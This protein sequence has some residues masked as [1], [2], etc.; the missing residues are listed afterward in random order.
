MPD[1]SDASSAFR[2]VL[3]YIY[4]GQMQLYSDGEEE[5][6]QDEPISHLLDV[7][8]LAANL[9]LDEL[10]DSIAT[11]LASLTTLDNCVQI[12]ERAC[13]FEHA[14][15]IEHTLALID[16]HSAHFV[17]RNVTA[18]VRLPADLLAAILARDSF[19]S[20]GAAEF[21]IVALVERW[22]RHHNLSSDDGDSGLVTVERNERLLATVRLEL[23][24]ASQLRHLAKYS[25]PL[26][27]KAAIYEAIAWQND[28]SMMQVRRRAAPR[29]QPR[30]VAI[31][32]GNAIH[33]W[34]VNSGRRVHTLNKSSD[35]ECGHFVLEWLPGV[36][37]N[38][39]HR[40]ANACGNKVTF[41]SSVN[42]FTNSS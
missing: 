19:G 13:T 34:N 16:E 3:A 24:D 8:G 30:R 21:D 40:L 4:S 36:G 18:L 39:D 42:I 1:L 6:E 37:P 22:H 7:L 17:Q 20:G 28:P 38:G 2:R 14:A 12:Y 5:E 33:I 15:L 10:R 31:G 27:D 25:T 41:F 29:Q 9:K 11:H 23:C 35:G 26:V 32:L